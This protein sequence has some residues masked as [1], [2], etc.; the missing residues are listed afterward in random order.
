M[1][2]L[3]ILSGLFTQS[4][5]I[6]ALSEKSGTDSSQTKGILETALPML[7]NALTSNA[8]SESGATSL[9]GA[10]QQHTNTSS[11]A[12]QITNADT[13]DGNKIIGHILGD[14]K[15]DVIQT[16][17]EKT[18]ADTK[19][20]SNLLSSIA[21]GMMS[22]LS[23]VA[24][25]AQKTAATA[26]DKTAAVAKAAEKTGST[27]LSAAKKVTL[28][29]P[30]KAAKEETA[31]QE[32]EEKAETVKAEAEKEET[33]K[34]DAAGLNLSSLLGMFGVSGSQKESSGVLGDLLG[35]LG[36]LFG[37]GSSNSAD[38][39]SDNSSKDSSDN[40][41]PLLSILKSFLG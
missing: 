32:K 10:L 6:D 3:N 25:A 13:E 35:G 20:V 7:L 28:A 26:A 29:S 8:S 17:S 9:L 4:S 12:E 41:N 15:T 2:L 16:I 39:N 1:D 38:S 27:L 18:G 19:Q 21:P 34:E 36:G 23:A 14:K 37:G 31:A 30:L 24:S 33:E 22:G 11:M 5:S 40:S